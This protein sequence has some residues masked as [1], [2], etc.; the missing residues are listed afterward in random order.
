MRC[1]GNHDSIQESFE[2]VRRSNVAAIWAPKVRP[3]TDC[4]YDVGQGT[5]CPRK[6][7]R[8]ILVCH[9]SSPKNDCMQRPLSGS[10]AEATKK[11]ETTVL[12]EGVL[13]AEESNATLMCSLAARMKAYK[14]AR[15][16]T[17]LVPPPSVDQSFSR[18]RT[19]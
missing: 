18:T 10:S 11:M 16:N 19:Q 1:A 5:R 6:T 4:A 12:A 8:S 14:G 7:A 3:T 2:N 9:I 15:I 17:P 13:A